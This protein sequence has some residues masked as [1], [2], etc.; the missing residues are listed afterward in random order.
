LESPVFLKL[1][2]VEDP[3]KHVVLRG[4]TE[5]SLEAFYR[6]LRQTIQSERAGKE[7]KQALV[8]IHGFN[9]SFEDAARR[10][11]QLMYDLKF[12]GAPIFYSWPSQRAFLDYAVDETN[13]EWTVPHLEQFLHEIAAN[14]GAEKI[15][16][17]AHSMGNRCLAKVEDSHKPVTSISRSHPHRAGHRCR[18]FQE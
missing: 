12:K 9:V 6:N 17:I 8:F 14:S 2:Y 13:V 11:A 5:Q 10:T 4:V 16:L 1:E 7:V 3:K 15:Y 18:Q